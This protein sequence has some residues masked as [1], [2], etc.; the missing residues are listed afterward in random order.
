MGKDDYQLE[1]VLGR[2]A[3][4]VVY[5]A[6]R[7]TDGVITAFKE[8]NPELT[9][10][11]AYIAR[12]DREATNMALIANPHC[13][14]LYEHGGG[15]PGAW[16][17][18]E[19]VHGASLRAVLSAHGRLTAE[20]ACGVLRGALLGLGNAHRLDVVHRDVKPEN[21]LVDTGGVSKLGDFGLTAFRGSA[22]EWRMVEGTPAY[23]SPEQV[24]G[25]ALDGRSDL[26]AAAVVFYEL[27][28][29]GLPFAGTDPYSVLRAQVESEPAR[30]EGQPARV[31]ELLMRGLAKDRDRRPATAEAF[32]A[33]LEEAAE[34]DL[35]AGWLAAAGI[36]GLVI[37]IVAASVGTAE[38]A[39]STHSANAHTGGQ[40]RRAARIASRLGAHAGLKVAAGI[41]ALAVVGG[42]TGAVAA[43]SSSGHAKKPAQNAATARASL[44]SVTLPVQACP[45]SD[46]TGPAGT[47][48]STVLPSPVS[49]ATEMTVNLVPSVASEVAVYGGV[50][51][52][53][54]VTYMLGPKGLQ[55]IEVIQGAV[56]S[57]VMNL[58]SP[59]AAGPIEALILNG[60]G[61]GD[62][63]SEVCPFFAASR[64]A[65]SQN[66][67]GTAECTLPPGTH[68]APLASTVEAYQEPPSE[69]QFPPL[70]GVVDL[71]TPIGGIEQTCSLTTALADI[72]ESSFIFFLDSFHYPGA[73]GV[74]LLPWFAGS[75]SAGVTGG[76]NGTAAPT[77]P[78]STSPAPPAATGGP[79]AYVTNE[80]TG[81]ITSVNLSTG[82]LG[83]PIHIGNGSDGIAITPDGRTAYVCSPQDGTVTPVDLATG[84][85]GTPIP[86]PGVGLGIA[87][88]PDGRAA[89]VTAA[90]GGTLTPI[91]L[92]AGTVG[93][94]IQIQG[95]AGGAVAITPDGKTAY[96]TDSG[97]SL[98]PVD[99]TTGAA[100]SPISVPGAP[101]GIAITPDGA[102]AWVVDS[103]NDDVYPFTLS[104]GKA[105]ATIQM[106]QGAGGAIVMS[107]DGRTAYLTTG[108]ET[109]V[110]LDLGSGTFGPGESAP[111]GD[112]SGLAL[113]P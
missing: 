35:G 55:C 31:T 76:S 39:P 51:S 6:R 102:T 65:A 71:V 52:S 11:P 108:G 32:L 104:S 87:V 69:G 81:D 19:Y 4:G 58:F 36:A 41:A 94:P 45:F 68:T 77:P 17:A 85:P 64:A 57:E 95:G 101:T 25:E 84:A 30:P 91:S 40:A 21:I 79:V 8:L 50:D 88:S 109:V 48:S 3:T 112:G 67:F 62:N 63:L 49:L 66:G 61:L 106:P 74:P 78:A 86:V 5:R 100:G 44:L 98:L 37:G 22:D 38:A 33:E 9:G 34:H 82:A 72:C 90:I 15:D 12:F 29:G 16:I 46:Q 24:R 18:M 42:V 60:G 113:V 27:L 1:S 89:Y 97:G 70:D 54:K 110:S 80:S 92:P 93:T 56:A 103:I 26:Y 28:T 14:A 107:A 53:G 75:Q 13:V 2:G 111:L 73:A 7:V 10:D 47:S 23:M 105:G 43:G 20:Q 96:V 59:I 99:L 83:S